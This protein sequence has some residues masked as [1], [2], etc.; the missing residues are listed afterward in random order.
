MLRLLALAMVVAL[1]VGC[2]VDSF[3]WWESTAAGD[4]LYVL[5]KKTGDLY[6]I[7]DG[8]MRRVAKNSRKEWEGP[9]EPVDYEVTA[10]TH[11]VYRDAWLFENVVKIDVRTKYRNGEVEIRGSVTPYMK[12]VW[13]LYRGKTFTIEFVD[14]EMFRVV[15][16]EIDRSDLIETHDDTGKPALFS[17]VKRVPVAPESWAEAQLISP[18]WTAQLEK[19]V[20]AW[21]KANPNDTKRRQELSAAEQLDEAARF[22]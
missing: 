12:E 7:Q 13:A 2:E 17:F 9:T 22:R 5:N 21:K 11:Q 19:A 1:G 3:N 4:R 6:T 20:T 8:E 15:E 18:G 14:Q 10:R 16:V